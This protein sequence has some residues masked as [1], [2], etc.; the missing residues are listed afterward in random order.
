MLG[1]SHV[2]LPSSMPGVDDALG[3]CGVGRDLVAD[4]EERRLG[5]VVVQDLQQPVGVGARPVV[6]RQRHTLDL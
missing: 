1:C 5:V 4:L 2:W 6:E 3:A